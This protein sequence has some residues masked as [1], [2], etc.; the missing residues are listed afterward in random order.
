MTQDIYIQ[1]GGRI[2][3]LRESRGYTREQLAEIADISPKF[4]YD[5]E[6]GKKGFSARTL[7][8]LADGLDV[9]CDYIIYGTVEYESRTELD[10]VLNRFPDDKIDKIIRILNAIYQLSI[11]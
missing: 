9:S 4:L 5:I 6:T 7:S 3:S 1:A 2:R 11:V 8:M 10:Y